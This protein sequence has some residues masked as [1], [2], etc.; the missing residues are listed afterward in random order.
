MDAALENLDGRVGNVPSG[1]DLQSEITALNSAVNT[2]TDILSD[3]LLC[4][5]TTFLNG[6]GVSY[7]GALPPG[8]LN[9][10]KWSTFMVNVKDTIRTVLAHSPENI[11][12]TNIYDNGAWSGWQSLA[13]NS[14][15]VIENV[16]STTVNVSDSGVNKISLDVSKTGYTPKGILAVYIDV[17]GSTEIILDQF[18]INGSSAYIYFK[19]S[20]SK[21][22]ATLS[23]TM[24]YQ[25]S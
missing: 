25:K 24:L 23:V 9:S 14:K 5:E 22:G 2:T 11:I 1:T 3:A 16:T 4:A 19:S 7:I 13:L 17:Y 18:F 20:Q 6:A 12:Y 15:F 10:F 8:A 21:N